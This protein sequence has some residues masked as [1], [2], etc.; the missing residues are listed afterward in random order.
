MVKPSYLSIRLSVIDQIRNHCIKRLP[1]E[2]YGILAGQASEIT[3][4]FSIPNTNSSPCTLE[5]EPRAYLDTIKK[6]RDFRLE[7]LGVVHSHPFTHAYPS[8][9]DITSWN[10]PNKSCWIISLKG[11]DFHLSAYYIEKNEV[12]PIM[13]HITGTSL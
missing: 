2:G 8:T 9:R 1:M 12:I 10:F 6:I 4:F 11:S 13:Y 3:H 5:F 7:W